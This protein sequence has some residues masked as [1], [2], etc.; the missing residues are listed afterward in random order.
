M[1]KPHHF[2]REKDRPASG[3]TRC[4]I[5]AILAGLTFTG[6]F[7]EAHC[8][9]T[10][11]ISPLAAIAS[12]PRI[13]VSG[14][15]TDSSGEPI[16]GASVVVLNTSIGTMTDIDGKFSLTVEADSK[17][18]FT[19][20]GMETATVDVDN[21]TTVNVT[22]KD[23]TRS[24][25]EVVV[26]GYGSQKK[27]NLTGAVSVV[28]GEQLSARTANN[29]T[30]LLQG[31]VPNMNI[32]MTN[33]RPGEGGSINIRGVQTVS[34]SSNGVQPLVLIDGVEGDIN[35]VNPSDVESISVLKDASSA[36]V[37]GARAAFGVILVTTRAGAK[38][39][40]HVSYSGSYSFSRPTVSTDFET[41][42][43][44]GA[45][46]ND[47]F[48]KPYQGQNYTTY[49]D[50][51][52]Y[53]LWLR[54]NDKTENP[55]R[56]WVM[57]KDGQYKYYANTDWYNHLYNESRPTWNQNIAVNGGTDKV[58]YWL[59]GNY[60]SQEGVIRK[61]EDKFQKYNFRSKIDV[62]ANK[63]LRFSNNTS[64]YKDIYN[65]KG[66]AGVNGQFGCYMTHCLPSDVPVNPDGSMVIYPSS[67]PQ[68]SPGTGKLA[69]LENGKHVNADRASSFQTTFQATVTPI[70]PLEIVGNFTYLDYKKRYMNRSSNVWFSN[71]PGKLTLWDTGSAKNELYQ[72]DNF[73][74]YYS[75]NLY[76]T[77]SETFGGAHHLKATAGINYE[78][79]RYENLS[80]TRDNLVSDDL[81]DFNLATGETMTIS[82]GKNQYKLF[83]VFYRAN[84]DY[85]GRYLLEAGGR[86]DGSSRFKSGHRYGFFPSVSAGWRI[87]EEAF[88][89]P[90]RAAVDNLK[91]RV[92]YGELGNQQSVGYY[93]YIQTINTSGK[94]GYL[95]NGE[96]LNQAY[97]SDPNA[98]N[99][100]WETVITKNVGV[101]M[102]FFNTRLNLSADVYQRD[103][104]DILTNGMDLPGVY[105][106]TIPKMNAADIR[107]KGWE[108]SLTWMDQFNIADRPFHYS[109]TAGLADNTAKVMQFNNPQKILGTP[110]D[111]MV[112]G[113]IWGYTTDGY[114]LTDDEAANYPVDQT[115]VNSFLNIMAIDAGLHAGD[116][117]YVDL[118]GNNKI[119]PTLSAN[120]V[121]DQKVI[122]NSM[123]RYTYS[124]RTTAEYAGF[125]LSAMLQG[126]GHQDWYPGTETNLYWFCYSRPYQSFI[127]SDF[128]GKI[129]TDENPNAFFPRPRGYVALG[130]T[131]EL[132]AVNNRYLEN[133]AYCR[134]KNVILGYTLP[135]KWLKTLQM[136]KVRLYFSGEN[137]LT[138]TTLR[139]DY[140]DPEIAGA[141]NTW[142][143]GQT[144]VSGTYPNNKQFTFGVDVTF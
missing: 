7:V 103:T 108:F 55:D 48:F 11:V 15:V 130:N 92:S 88:F 121:K 25:E 138:F 97:V 135:S 50:E 111:G 98:D 16:V 44:Y 70:T 93:D 8:A 63:W 21:R 142:R 117:K 43:Y 47:L 61:S 95:M 64:Y 134:L 65:Y 127:P 20:I 34:G 26:V 123:P 126:I 75:Y 89:S 118:D 5:S 83:G 100:T 116:L 51:D 96:R 132:G 46:I 113:E 56:P 14:T 129:W 17:L 124:F 6:G 37:Y 12:A 9:S 27:V 136:E 23:N 125:D 18:R 115:Y 62:T 60:Y 39:S 4:S 139:N 141:Q 106:A 90:L 49:T 58:K 66:L 112:L 144:N 79:R 36:A 119:E 30:Q 72:A 32:R 28:D 140:I 41:R 45:A 133:V 13:T 91:L 110:Y 71:E 3:L 99:L 73:S 22:L 53:E 81:I 24:L 137:L 31:A 59:S 87:S 19:Y 10:T 82:G 114:F 1:L 33:G 35:T 86:Y 67:H 38:G 42:G 109:A 78:N 104:R 105:G 143:Y 40:N 57:I 54:R 52:Y 76:S 69:I 74:D 131:R 2:L 68:Y 84:Y 94:L 101:D 80:A 85:R 102:T 77:Y 29:M 120:N 128:M 107:T 122:G